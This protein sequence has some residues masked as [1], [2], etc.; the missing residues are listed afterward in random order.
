MATA[1]V[2]APVVETLIDIAG[3]SNDQ[4]GQEPHVRGHHVREHRLRAPYGVADS[5]GKAT[6]QGATMYVAFGDGNWHNSKYEITDTLPGMITVNGADSIDF[7]RNVDQAQ[8]QRGHLD[9]Q[10]RGQLRRSSATTSPTSPGSGIT[11]GHPQHV[12]L[13]D[14]GTHAKYAAGVEGICTNNSI[15]NNVFYDVSS[16]RG[17]GGHAGDHGVLR[18]T[19]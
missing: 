5:C 13:G 18:R 15:A 10:R 1:D 8:R 14:G 4:P 7:V 6:V 3:T 12:Y 17:F 19:A 2:E 11:V 9:D 16:V